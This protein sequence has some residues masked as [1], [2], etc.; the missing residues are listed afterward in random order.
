MAPL[1]KNQY[2]YNEVRQI[3]SH[4]SY[5]ERGFIPGGPRFKAGLFEQA[6]SGIRSFEFDIH[7]EQD[8]GIG[9][10]DYR[11]SDWGIY[12]SVGIGSGG[13]HVGMLSE[14]LRKFK[15]WHNR[16]RNHAVITVWLQVAGL[17]GEDGWEAGGHKPVD[18]DNNRL[19]ADM[20]NLLYTPLDLK[21]N[22]PDNLSLQSVIRR[23]GWP[24]LGDLRGKFIIVLHG[25]DRHL[26]GYLHDVNNYRGGLRGNGSYRRGPKCCFVAPEIKSA[27]AIRNKRN[28]VFF[29]L[30]MENH[31]VALSVYRANFVSRIYNIDNEAQWKRARE[32]KVHHLGT[33]H[34]S[35]QQFGPPAIDSEGLP[36]EP[37][38]R[39][40]TQKMAVIAGMIRN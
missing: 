37:I 15:R 29:N 10:I 31:K 26:N 1:P 8:P 33:D 2:R 25:E 13:D 34:I 23:H 22:S 32:H 16:H 6:N 7:K 27:A 39:R 18:L 38:V 30:K 3:H 12:H 21:R 24:T 4:N 20:G 35:I 17:L 40:T 5:D 19:A 9:L 11:H 36:L 28:C 14:V